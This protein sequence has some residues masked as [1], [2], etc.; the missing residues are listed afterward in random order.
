MVNRDY[1]P[2]DAVA[3]I[4]LSGFEYYRDILEA[5]D[6]PVFRITRKTQAR[7]VIEF[8]RQNGS[9]RVWIVAAHGV[10]HTQTLRDELAEAV[11]VL[12]RWQ[13]KGTI[14]LLLDFSKR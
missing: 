13:T 1:E 12:F 5:D 11:P 2:G 9:R 3:V 8:A 14:V 7:S 6:V 4:P 10:R